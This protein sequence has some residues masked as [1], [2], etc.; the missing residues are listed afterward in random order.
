M[1][2]N[3]WPDPGIHGKPLIGIYCWV[4]F[5]K[6]KRCDSKH[7]SFAETRSFGIILRCSFT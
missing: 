4:N 1:F 2:Q 5:A 3:D 6:S 7:S